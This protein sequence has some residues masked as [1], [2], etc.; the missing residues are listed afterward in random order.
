MIAATDA[1]RSTECAPMMAVLFVGSAL[2]VA[3]CHRRPNDE[4]PRSTSAPR[5]QNDILFS[6]R[7]GHGATLSLTIRGEQAI[8]G[9]ANGGQDSGTV[10]ASPEQYIIRLRDGIEY[11]VDRVNGRLTIW[12][13]EKP[14]TNPPGDCRRVEKR[15]GE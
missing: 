13:Q 11:R 9:Y 8:L 2:M 4:Q 6:C 10:A 14:G 12:F 5:V 1:R 3:A 15:L 7:E